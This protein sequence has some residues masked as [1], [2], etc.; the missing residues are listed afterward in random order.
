MNHSCGVN[1]NS[2]VPTCT[3]KPGKLS[4]VFP[5][6]EKSENFKML[7]KSQGKVREFL[8]SQGKVREI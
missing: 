6:R 7:P 5:V 3:G 4:E 8:S 1:V 2:R